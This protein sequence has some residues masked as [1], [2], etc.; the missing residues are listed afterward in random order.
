MDDTGRLTDSAFVRYD[1]T[2]ENALRHAAA[3]FSP[4]LQ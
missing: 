2:D 3:K 1:I 4:L